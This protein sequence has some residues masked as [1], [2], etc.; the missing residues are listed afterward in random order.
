[1]NRMETLLQALATVVFT[2]MNKTLYHAT[3]LFGSEARLARILAN[4]RK[5]EGCGMNRARWSW[6]TMH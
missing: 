2:D 1:M 6:V 4:A 5:V 3:S